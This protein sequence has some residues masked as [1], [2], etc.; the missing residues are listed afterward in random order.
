MK[1]CFLSVHRKNK[2][3]ILIFVYLVLCSSSPR[4]IVY[5]STPNPLH[6]LLCISL[7]FLITPSLLFSRSFSVSIFLSLSLCLYSL[8]P[9]VGI[10]LT[11][12]FHSFH[13]RVPSLSTS[14]RL[15]DTHLPLLATPH[16]SCQLP[17][18][19]FESLVLLF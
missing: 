16:T 11:R 17:T 15:H 14:R 8:L 13:R 9:P 5:R 6:S 2:K 10:P 4:C 19:G 18:K 7:L 12:R 1:K 3:N